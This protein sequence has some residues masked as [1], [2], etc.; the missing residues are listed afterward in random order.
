MDA[1]N[2]LPEIFSRLFEG[3]FAAPSSLL[4]AALRLAWSLRIN[5]AVC[6]WSELGTRSHPFVL[7]RSH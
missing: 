6:A 1:G 5:P 2:I 3:R 4:H 7:S